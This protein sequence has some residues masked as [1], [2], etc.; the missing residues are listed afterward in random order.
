LAQSADLINDIDD[1]PMTKIATADLKQYATPRQLEYLEAIEKHGSVD[2]AAQ[3]LK[4][5]AETLTRVV[6][7]LKGRAAQQG[8]SPS[9]DMV[10]TV[11]E[12]FKVKGVST[13]Y[14]DDGKVRGQWVKSVADDAAREK[15]LEEFAATLADSVKGLAQPVKAPKP[16]AGADDL[17]CVIPMGDPHFGMYAW[18]QEAGNDFDLDI[19]E[20]LTRSAIDRLVDSGPVAREALLLN[21]GD[22]FHADNQKNLSQSGHQLD[23]DGRWSKVQQVGLRAMIYCVQQLL[24]KYPKVTVRINRGNHDGHSSYALSLM[25]S[26]FFHN[27]PRVTIDLSPAFHWYF[28][29]GKVLIGSTHGDTTKDRDM[30]P[31]MAADRPA[32]WGSS[33]H[34]YWYVGHVHHKHV[35]EHPGG[36]VEYFR[37]LAP[38]DAWHRGQGYRAGRDMCLI[39]HHAEYGEIERHRCDVGMVSY[40]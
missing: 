8:W 21:L 38:G 11:P 3:K 18:A 28:Q 14:D 12:G 30:L 7:T 10:H 34:R 27:E 23:V 6:R 17:L 1:E 25:L 24:V 13:L 20:K 19:A 32:Q 2:K 36:I 31:I 33:A 4:L 37:T 29:F 16:V 9:H 15:M 40:G 5:S 35:K 22:H 26:C 39:V